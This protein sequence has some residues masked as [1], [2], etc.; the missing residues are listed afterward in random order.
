MTVTNRK[1]PSDEAI[2]LINPPPGL[3]GNEHAAAQR[4]AAKAEII[5]DKFIC[6][7]LRS[8]FP[9]IELDVTDYRN[10]LDELLADAGVGTDPVQRMLVEQFGFAHLRLSLLQSQATVAKSLDAHKVLNG[11]CARLLGELRRT[12][13]TIAELK[14]TG[15]APAAPRLKVAKTG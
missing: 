9:G 5:R 11:A 2:D 7:T 12:A 13:L 8:A 10:Y 4:R 15:T 3:D 6:T 1:R 14:R